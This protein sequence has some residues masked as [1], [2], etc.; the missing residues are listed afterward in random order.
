MAL[1]LPGREGARQRSTFLPGI[2]QNEDGPGTSM[3]RPAPASAEPDVADRDGVLHSS[4]SEAA[5]KSIACHWSQAR[6]DE[7]AQIARRST[8]SDRGPS[9]FGS[10][11]GV[12]GG[13]RSSDA[14]VAVE[15]E[16][17]GMPSAKAGLFFDDARRH[18]VTRHPS[19]PNQVGD[20]C[21]G[22]TGVRCAKLGAV[23]DLSPPTPGFGGVDAP[24][25]YG[26]AGWSKLLR[27]CPIHVRRTPYC[28]TGRVYEHSCRCRVV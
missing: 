15:R 18:W 9:R 26:H 6:A 23:P 2:P 21:P 3:V 11:G 16:L 24:A 22:R 25:S 14:T 20:V 10:G 4:R 13:L 7:Q 5:W 8:S 27:K 19:P 17:S 1:S 12:P 28:T